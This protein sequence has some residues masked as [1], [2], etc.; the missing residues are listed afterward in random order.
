MAGFKLPNKATETI[1]DLS[2]YGGEGALS[3]R[4]M[5]VGD[6]LELTSYISSL[7]DDD[8]IEVKGYED[9]QH[10]MATRYNYKTMAFY[11]NRC[12]RAIEDGAKRPLTD[13]EVVSLP[14]ELLVDIMKVLEESTDFPLEQ[15]GGKAR[16]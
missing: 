13:D 12:V 2:K 1:I 4:D 5:Q 14:V 9:I 15:K 10:L 3:V 11:I 8:G 7:A 6:S 16:K